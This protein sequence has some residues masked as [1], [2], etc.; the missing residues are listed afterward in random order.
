MTLH[1]AKVEYAVDDLDLSLHA[2][3][4]AR[5]FARREAAM[6]LSSRP[7]APGNVLIACLAGRDGDSPIVCGNIAHYARALADWARTCISQP[8]T[9]ALVERTRNELVAALDEELLNALMRYDHRGS[10]AVVDALIEALSPRARVEWLGKQTPSARRR[11][12]ASAI[13]ISRFHGR[14]DPEQTLTSWVR[15]RTAR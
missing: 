15:I 9:V 2:T 8:V 7:P 14:L 12:D 3:L 5:A 10:V 11:A 6:P 1:A 4:A 13:G